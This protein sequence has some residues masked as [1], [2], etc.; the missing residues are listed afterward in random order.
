MRRGLIGLII[1]LLILLGV[2]LCKKTYETYQFI[3]RE[4][5]TINQYSYG[6]DNKTL[7]NE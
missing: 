3:N 5:L 2:F 6:I 1:G 7:T 4:R